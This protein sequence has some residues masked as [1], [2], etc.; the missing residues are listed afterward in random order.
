MKRALLPRR[1]ISLI[2][3]LALEL[4]ACPL[5]LHAACPPNSVQVGE[6]DQREGNVMII[7]PVCQWLAPPR[8]RYVFNA[9]PALPR[10]PPEVSDSSVKTALAR[11]R[12]FLLQ[13]GGGTIVAVVS[14]AD[15]T[16]SV[17]Y[18]ATK[19]PD[20][21]FPKISEVAAMNA[22][23]NAANASEAEALGDQI[24]VKSVI[25]LFDVGGGQGNET[26]DAERSGSSLFSAFFPKTAAKTEQWVQTAPTWMPDIKRVI[27]IWA[28]AQTRKGS[29]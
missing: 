9:V 24:T 14:E 18:N 22:D 7:H 3:L 4:I 26:A 8:P 25:T 19:L 21:I 1:R 27:G 28:P 10:V 15:M 5:T 13:K 16:V 20:V 23:P 17:M 29:Q 2:R 6:Q 11:A 12:A